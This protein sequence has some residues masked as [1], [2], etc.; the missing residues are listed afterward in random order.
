MSLKQE[1]H[2]EGADNIR[3]AIFEFIFPAAI[4][5]R[6]VARTAIALLFHHKFKINFH[7]FHSILQYI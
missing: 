3:K 5:V 4:A 1:R 6:A 7:A 2:Q